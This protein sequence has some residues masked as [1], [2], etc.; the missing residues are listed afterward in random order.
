MGFGEI[1][2][3]SA[4]DDAGHGAEGWVVEADAV[5]EFLVG[6]ADV[7]VFG[8]EGDSG[9]VWGEGL[10]EDFSAAIAATGT[11]SDLGDEVEGS[12][13]SAEIGEVESG[14]GIDDSDEEDV[15]K[16]ETFGDHLGPEKDLEGSIAELG[17]DPFVASWFSHGI[18]IHAT[19]A[20]GGEAFLDFHFES[21][22]PE[23][24]IANFAALAFRAE[25]RCGD[26]VVAVV[27]DGFTAIVMVGEWEIA[28][29]AMDDVSAVRALD[30][31]GETAT[32]EEEHALPIEVEGFLDGIVEGFADG[33]VGGAEAWIAEVD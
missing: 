29:R 18:G 31:R 16:V 23:S 5:F 13:G 3:G 30:A 8:G 9:V 32:I 1:G 12:F 7:V 10:E 26:G 22:G 19:D 11:T 4:Q 15:G 33:A 2:I 27:A 20:S 25:G 28:I 6:E 17:E 14:I 21:L 24:A